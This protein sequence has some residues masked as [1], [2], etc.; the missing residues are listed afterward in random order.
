MDFKSPGW[1]GACWMRDLL[2]VESGGRNVLGARK[3]LPSLETNVLRS[4]IITFDCFSK[5]LRE[6][7][8]LSAVGGGWAVGFLRRAHVR[9]SC[10]VARW[11]RVSNIAGWTRLK[12]CQKHP[13]RLDIE[14]FAEIYAE[15]GWFNCAPRLLRQKFHPKRFILPSHGTFSP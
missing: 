3:K 14:K 4:L 13:S 8:I 9:T 7:N 15:S 6:Q 1:R 11:T 12:S 2:G 5:C 10:E